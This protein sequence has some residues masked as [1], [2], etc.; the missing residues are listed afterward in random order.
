MKE[1]TAGRVAGRFWSR[2]RDRFYA[3]LSLLPSLVLVFVFVCLLIGWN[4]IIAFSKWSG[5]QTDRSFNG[6]NNFIELAQNERFQI[7]MKN[8]GVFALVFIS[9]CIV[10]GF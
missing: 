3:F 6:L 2:H 10:L 9:G 5:L 4:T 1:K 8:M 7:G